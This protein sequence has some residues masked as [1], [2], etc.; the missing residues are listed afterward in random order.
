[1]LNRFKTALYNVVGSFDPGDGGA[2]GGLG[3]GVTSG[4]PTSAVTGRALT[5]SSKDRGLRFPYTRPHFLQL[6][7]EDEI[8]VTADHAIRPIICPRDISRLPWNSGYAETIN[9]GKS[10]KN[11]DQAVVHVGLLT[12]PLRLDRGAPSSSSS[13]SSSSSPQDARNTTSKAEP[14]VNGHS[15]EAS[16]TPQEKTVLLQPRGG[17]HPLSAS[18]ATELKEG[19]PQALGDA[20]Q[21]QTKDGPAGIKIEEGSAEPLPHEPPQLPPV[22]HVSL[23]YYLFGVF[24][25]H[26][27]WGAAVAAAN[28]LH[29]IVHEKL[30]D[31]IDI[32]IPDPLEEKLQSPIWAP[33]REVTMESAVTGALENAFWQ[34]DHTIAEDRL[35]FQLTGG[36]TACVGLFIHGK[37]FLA[38][39]GD[40]RAILS[41]GGVPLPMSF[42]FTPESENQRIRKLG[43][44]HPELL[45]GEFTHLDFIRRP[46]RRDLGKRVLFRDHYMS[47]WAYKTLTPDDLKY[48]LVCGEGKRSRVLATIGV[49]RGFG[50][51][52]L[53]AQ[54]SS[55]P[56]KPFLTPEPEV[57]VFDIEAA[58]LTD[59]DVL[60]LATD[61]LWDITS[62]ERAVSMVSKSLSHF[63]PDHHDK[64][65]YTSA[66]QDL[67]MGSR[68]KLRERNWRTSDDKHATIDDISVFVVPLRPYQVEHREWKARQGRPPAGE[69]TTAGNKTGASN[70]GHMPPLVPSSKQDN[71]ESLASGKHSAQDGLTTCM[72]AFDLHPQ[73]DHFRSEGDA[74]Q[75]EGG[76]GPAQGPDTA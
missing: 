72:E 46:Q 49:T 28:Q 36:C 30:C 1:M 69:E 27:G 20:P 52:D 45:G 75:T 31:V 63:P 54:C 13:S 23:P 73:E 12:R 50:D 70:N 33:E 25:G 11:E 61:G 18:P 43:A 9:A 74:A 14:V 68:G 15:E 16:E 40:S 32:L 34:M 42:D 39:A 47:G 67:V 24:D 5:G 17:Q 19:F 6:G 57:R 22:V 59:G 76:E 29:H 48:P 51:H 62:N 37:L 65:K 53:K 58:E 66:A 38:N 10:K 55:I 56:I 64:H 26:A 71:P 7:S 8:Q 4:L 2:L 41:L 3:P 60:V 21:D 44:M 35:R